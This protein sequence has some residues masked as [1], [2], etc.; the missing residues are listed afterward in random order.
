MDEV[1]KFISYHDLAS[2]LLQAICHKK[3]RQFHDFPVS[4]QHESPNEHDHNKDCLTIA[5][6]P[7]DADDLVAVRNLP[8]FLIQTLIHTVW[9]RSVGRFRS[10]AHAV[11]LSRLQPGLLLLRLRRRVMSL[12]VVIAR[13]RLM[14][15]TRTTGVAGA[16]HDL[17]EADRREDNGGNSNYLAWSTVQKSIEEH[18]F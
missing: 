1:V 3:G 14:V 4:E 5:A 10:V 17:V 6:G 8:A 7:D 12:H 9:F 16:G 18:T 13:I 15:Q 2:N 11:L